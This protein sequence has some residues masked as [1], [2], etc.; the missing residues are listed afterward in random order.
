MATDQNTGTEDASE[1][2]SLSETPQEAAQDDTD[3]QLAAEESVGADL[4]GDV[5]PGPGG[6]YDEIAP[7]DGA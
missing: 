5:V 1:I 7:D 6:T 3:A 2:S 4:A